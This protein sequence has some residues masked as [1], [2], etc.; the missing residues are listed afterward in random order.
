M[1]NVSA[2]VKKKKKVPKVFFAF[3][4]YFFDHNLTEGAPHGLVVRLISRFPR[5]FRWLIFLQSLKSFPQWSSAWL[6]VLT[7]DDKRSS[8]V[9]WMCKNKESY[10]MDC[11]IHKI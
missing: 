10:T 7:S 5:W 2:R 1:F 8:G 4:G 3:C 11:H 9:L 6:M